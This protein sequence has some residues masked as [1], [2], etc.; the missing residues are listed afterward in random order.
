MGAGFAACFAWQLRSGSASFYFNILGRAERNLNS[1]VYWFYQSVCGLAA[2]AYAVVGSGILL[3]AFRENT[4]GALFFLPFVALLV[5][6]RLWQ[7]YELFH[8]RP[9]PDYKDDNTDE[10]LS[11]ALAE[12]DI[13]RTA[14]ALINRYGRRATAQA[15]ERAEALTQLGDTNGASVWRAVGEAVGELQKKKRTPK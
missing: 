2:I 15:I 9:A 4:I 12:P 3:G 13:D 14:A 1:T 10:A 7:R 5:W 6:L 11:T 8:G